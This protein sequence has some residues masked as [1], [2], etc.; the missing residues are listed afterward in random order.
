MSQ[1]LKAS[2][3][4][5]RSN[6]LCPQEGA[7]VQ[8]F[9]PKKKVKLWAELWT[10]PGAKCSVPFQRHSSWEKTIIDYFKLNWRHDVIARGGDSPRLPLVCGLGAVFPGGSLL[11]LQSFLLSARQVWKINRRL[12]EEGWTP[13]DAADA[14]DPH[15]VPMSP[16]SIARMSGLRRLSVGGTTPS[17]FLCSSFRC[18]ANVEK[19]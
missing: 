9:T 16:V 17:M 7:A 8:V 18:S 19:A 10:T 11:L 2:R 14:G 4:T 15:A 13:A 6:A 1:T 5:R 12:N 3:H